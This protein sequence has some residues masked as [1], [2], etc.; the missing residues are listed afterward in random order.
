MA[1]FKK[2]ESVQM[3]SG[4]PPMTIDGLPGEEKH[5]R[6]K[7]DEYWCRWFKGAT[8]ESGS[9]GEHLLVP[10]TPPSK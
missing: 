9:F 10:Y 5:Y 6:Q 4:G 8:E 2:G 3:A 7:P 1:K